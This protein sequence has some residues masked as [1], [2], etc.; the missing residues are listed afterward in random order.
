MV[1]DETILPTGRVVLIKDSLKSEEQWRIG[2]IEGQVSG[3]DGVVPGYKI[4]TGNG[5]IFERLIQLIAD[6]EIGG[7]TTNL[8]SKKRMAELITRS[9]RVCTV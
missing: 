1:Q 2:R 9:K 4:H 8:N 3:K 6:L 5:C 7:D